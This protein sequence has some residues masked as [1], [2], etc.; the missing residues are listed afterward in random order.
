[1]H[2][3]SLSNKAK[4]MIYGGGFNS[5]VVCDATLQKLDYKHPQKY[6]R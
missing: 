3:K 2:T 4:R 1:M 5:M 6:H